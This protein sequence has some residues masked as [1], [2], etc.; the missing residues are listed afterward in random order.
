MKDRRHLAPSHGRQMRKRPQVAV[1]GGCSLWG[2]HM[3]PVSV[4][5]DARF[6]ARFRNS[7]A[8]TT[9]LLVVMTFADGYAVAETAQP[10]PQEAT[11]IRPIDVGAR[12]AR[13]AARRERAIAQPKRVAAPRV[14]QS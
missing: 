4:S 11:Q 9:S 12:T 3:V 14:Q 7:L 8:S 5:D 13:P 2:R 10:T 6:F 1:T